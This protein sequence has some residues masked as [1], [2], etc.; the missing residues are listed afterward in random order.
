MEERLKQLRKVLGLN[1]QEFAEKINLG[2]STWAMI[3]VGKRALNDRHILLICSIFN[4]NEEW[5]R[6]GEGDMFVL[7]DR[8]DELAVWS[9]KLLNP[10]NDNEFMKKFVHML[11]RLDVDDW[12]VLEKMML[13]M[14]EENKK[15]QT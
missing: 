13:L 5:L 3:E 2:Q 12:K 9:G 10:N 1:Q 14:Q 11:S 4:V 6:S 8:E 7:L 15:D